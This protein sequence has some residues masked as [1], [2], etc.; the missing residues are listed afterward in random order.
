MTPESSCSKI[1]LRYCPSTTSNA[2][3]GHD[4][5]SLGSK[6]ETWSREQINDFVTKLGFFDAEKEGSIKRKHFL[7]IHEVCELYC[8]V[9][10]VNAH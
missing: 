5:L 10:T 1:L 4:S 6:T 9:D 8:I 3:S 2:S 7:Y